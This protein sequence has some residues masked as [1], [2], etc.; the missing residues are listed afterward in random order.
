M[1]YNEFFKIYNN[2]ILTQSKCGTRFLDK[3]F[4]A[5]EEI[6]SLNQLLDD[7]FKNRFNVVIIRDPYEH[8]LSA[9]STTYG[10]YGTIDN[11]LDILSKGHDPHWSPNLFKYLYIYGLKNK[12]T[13]LHLKDITNYIEYDLNLGKHNNQ[14]PYQTVKL[15]DKIFLDNLNKNHSEIWY[16]LQCLLKIEYSF[17]DKLIK[18][19][20]VY[21]PK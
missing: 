12:I 2:D 9:I 13:I 11:Q 20:E 16:Y 15:T 18:E 17:Y 21:Q 19:N 7:E 14:M 4:G 3:V 10:T 5:C 8:L 1:S 6:I